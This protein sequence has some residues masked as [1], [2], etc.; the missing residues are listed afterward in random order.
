M[1]QL[2]ATIRLQLFGHR[3]F[4]TLANDPIRLVDAD[5][6]KNKNWREELVDDSH[7]KAGEG[8]NLKCNH[9]TKGVEKIIFCFTWLITE[10][11]IFD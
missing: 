11:V 9:E 6:N 4:A 5:E 7:M 2:R 1:R 8:H 10:T 3:L